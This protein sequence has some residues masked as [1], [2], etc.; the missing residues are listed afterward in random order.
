MPQRKSAGIV[1]MVPVASD[2]EAEP[3]VWERFASRIVPLAPNN[4]KRATVR[5]AA[6]M[7]A[8]TVRPTR[9]PM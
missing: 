2:V 9:N 8:A 3:M 5:T 7:E 4:L 6:G 1:K